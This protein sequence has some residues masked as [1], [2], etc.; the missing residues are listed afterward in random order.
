MRDNRLL[1]IQ[2]AKDILQGDNTVLLDTETTGITNN[3]EVIEVA[4]IRAKTGELLLDTLIKPSKPYVFVDNVHTI[5][6]ED[7]QDSPTIHESGL[8]E[9]LANSLVITYNAQFDYRLLRQSY[10]MMG[11]KMPS[12]GF[13]CAML[14][15]AAYRSA[16]GKAHRW[17]KL[18]DAIKDEGI[19]FIQ[20]HRALSDILLTRQ[21]LQAM[22]ANYREVEPF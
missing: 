17:Y 20:E 16:P 3:S 1:A 11:Q 8:T 10:E 13:G 15:Y 7:L 22:E 5:T 12:K 18:S 19:D 9:I 2:A 6:W 21:I 4:V 14:M